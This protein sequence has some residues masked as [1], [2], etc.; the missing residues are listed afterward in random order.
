[1]LSHYLFNNFGLAIIALTIISKAVLYPINM[2]QLK[3]NR[4]M[5]AM[6]PKLL[7]IQRKYARDKQRLAHEQMQLYKETGVSPVGCMVPLLIQLPIMFALYQAI[8]TILAHFPD[9]FLELSKYLYPFSIVYSKLPLQSKFLW[10]NLSMPDQFYILP[11]LTGITMWLQQKQ[12]SLG[13]ADVQ[14]ASQ[15]KM[16]LWSMP[17]IFTYIALSFPSGLGL[18][19]VISSIISIVMQYFVSGWGGLS[20][21]KNMQLKL[22]WGGNNNINTVKRSAKTSASFP[23]ATVERIITEKSTELQIG[24]SKEG[25]S[26]STDESEVQLPLKGP[27]PPQPNPRK[28]KSRR[29]KGK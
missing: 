10:L 27:A 12:I 19:W 29:S 28:F 26:G 17:L 7:E 11:I 16:M 14:Q 15:Q 13:S 2:K 22:P 21:L 9:D 24:D 3:T 4:A 6:Q 8:T 18:Y 1:M 23:K 20:D 25:V 5:Q